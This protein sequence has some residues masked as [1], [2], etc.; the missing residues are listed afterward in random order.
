MKQFWFF[1]TIFALFLLFLY[2]V[3]GSI[4]TM[5][6]KKYQVDY[7]LE[8]TYKDATLTPQEAAENRRIE[9]LNTS[10][11]YQLTGYISVGILSITTIVILIIIRIRRALRHLNSSEKENSKT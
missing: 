6:S 11:N 10:L 8:Y 2:C 5:V 7:A 4:G 3:M 9:K 1:L